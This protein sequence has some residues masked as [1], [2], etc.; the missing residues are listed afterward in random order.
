M[1]PERDR[2]FE[3]HKAR[4]PVFAEYKQRLARMIPVM[5]R[6]PRAGA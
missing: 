3:A 1:D 5:R 6:K 4:Y 2:M